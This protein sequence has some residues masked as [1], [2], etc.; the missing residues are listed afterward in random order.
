MYKLDSHS[1]DNSYTFG[2]Y[3]LPRNRQQRYNCIHPLTS[4]KPRKRHHYI[5]STPPVLS[6]I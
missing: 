1:Q 4:R 2:D 3:D 6:T 5:R